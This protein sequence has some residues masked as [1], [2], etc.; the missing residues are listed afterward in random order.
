MIIVELIIIAI[1]VV[2]DYSQF[3]VEGRVVALASRAN[4]KISIVI[5]IENRTRTRNKT[6]YNEKILWFEK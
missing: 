1:L 3:P 5:G 6:T 4:Y 2:K